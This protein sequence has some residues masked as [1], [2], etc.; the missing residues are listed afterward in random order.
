MNSKEE[1]EQSWLAVQDGLGLRWRAWDDEVMLFQPIS[2]E[3]HCLTSLAARVLKILQEKPMTASQVAAALTRNGA[4]A[5]DLEEIRALLN[6]F[7]RLGLIS[8]INE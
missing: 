7:D 1:P 3:T 2:G 8:P 6:Q 4:N 5:A